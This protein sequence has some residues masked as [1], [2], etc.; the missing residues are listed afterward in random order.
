M[1][2]AERPVIVGPRRVPVPRGQGSIA[3]RSA[4]HDS[5][6]LVLRVA[7]RRR[8]RLFVQRSRPRDG[9]MGARL[10]SIRSVFEE[11]A[12]A[13]PRRAAALL[14]G[15]YRGALSRPAALVTA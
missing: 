12:Q 8:V 1:R 13:E 15:S 2:T 3:D 11:R 5:L 4:V 9:E 10:Q 7:P 6:P 14:R